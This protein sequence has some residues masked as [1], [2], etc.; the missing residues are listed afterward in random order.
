MAINNDNSLCFRI[1]VTDSDITDKVRAIFSRNSSNLS[2]TANPCHTKSMFLFV[3]VSHCDHSLQMWFTY[4]HAVPIPQN[5]NIP[6]KEFN[7]YFEHEIATYASNSVH[8]LISQFSKQY[9]SP[10]PMTNKTTGE[11]M[12]VR[13]Q[14]SGHHV[15]RKKLIIT[16]SEGL[17]LS[18]KAVWTMSLALK[19]IEDHHCVPTNLS[20]VECIDKLKG[21][22]L[23]DLIL[24]QTRDLNYDKLSGLGVASLVSHVSLY[25][26]VQSFIR[27]DPFP[28]NSGWL[29]IEIQCSKHLEDEQIHPQDRNIDMQSL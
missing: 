24:N 19:K 17:S 15:K 26:D 8:P 6:T 1:L 20:K 5:T 10:D 9:L 7:K 23:R 21:I 14:G 27:Y 29:S 2:S 18:M 16:S 12:E 11:G 4:R 13:S 25:G 22:G 28:L 3:P